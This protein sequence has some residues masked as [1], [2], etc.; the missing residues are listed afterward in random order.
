MSSKS[1]SLQLTHWPAAVSIE[2]VPSMHSEHG[3]WVTLLL[4]TVILQFGV[5][6]NCNISNSP[7]NKLDSI[8]IRLVLPLELES[9]DDTEIQIV[10]QSEAKNVLFLIMTAFSNSEQTSQDRTCSVEA[11]WSQMLI[12]STCSDVFVEFA[13]GLRFWS[14]LSLNF[15]QT[16]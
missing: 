4:L 15:K 10:E 6:S 13:H 14:F 5:P 11:T 2:C 3:V 16:V 8:M 12:G 1:S 9:S 7:W